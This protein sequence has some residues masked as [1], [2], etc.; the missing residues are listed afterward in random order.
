MKYIW[1]I[2]SLPK[3]AWIGCNTFGGAAVPSIEIGYLS[4]P[5]SGDLII[6]LVLIFPTRRGLNE[7]SIVTSL[8]AGILNSLGETVRYSFSQMI[9]CAVIG[10]STLNGLDIVKEPVTTSRICPI[11][12][13]V[14]NGLAGDIVTLTKKKTYSLLSTFSKVTWKLQGASLSDL[15]LSLYS[16][17]ELEATSIVLAPLINIPCSGFPQLTLNLWVWYSQLEMLSLIVVHSLTTAFALIVFW[18]EG[19]NEVPSTLNILAVPSGR[20]KNT[21]AS[22]SLLFSFGLFGSILLIVKGW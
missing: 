2:L 7:T 14:F 22:C 10:T 21:V 17:V 12:S 9:C 11:S 3:H 5:S 19:G 16:L 18:A 4:S 6:T 20:G 8:S 13:V 1:T 15:K